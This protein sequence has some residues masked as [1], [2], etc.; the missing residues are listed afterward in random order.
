[1]LLLDDP[2]YQARKAR[3]RQASNWAKVGRD[4]RENQEQIAKQ[5]QTI[6]AEAQRRLPPGTPVPGDVAMWE[7]GD[8]GVYRQPSVS[9][10]P[11]TPGPPQPQGLAEPQAEG[12]N[13][14]I[15]DIAEMAEGATGL[16]SD[17]NE[18]ARLIS[19]IAQRELLPPTPAPQPAKEASPPVSGVDTPPTRGRARR[20]AAAVARTFSRSPRANSREAQLQAER[21]AQLER[22]Q[23]DFELRHSSPKSKKRL[24][25]RFALEAGGRADVQPTRLRSGAGLPTVPEEPTFSLRAEL[26][27]RQRERELNLRPRAK[28]PPRKKL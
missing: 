27:R 3:I 5:A 26:Q 28:T 24:G 1:M 11:E 19:P 21:Q 22:R 10:Y 7:Q 25:A 14:D 2:E 17:M 16:Q 23:A 15:N 13:D 20:A 8:D 18:I 9:P 12:I 6:R 4:A